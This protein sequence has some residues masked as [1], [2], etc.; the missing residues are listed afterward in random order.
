MFKTFQDEDWGYF[1]DIQYTLGNFLKNLC[2]DN[3]IYFKEYFAKFVPNYEILSL[4]PAGARTLMFDLYVRLEQFTNVNLSYYKKNRRLD[5]SDRP[6]VL[7]IMLLFL[8]IV[9]ETVNGPCPVNQRKI[10]RYRTDTYMG[11]VTREIDD[12]NQAFYAL[13]DKTLDYIMSLMEGEGNYEMPDDIP[14]HQNSLYVTEFFAKNT[15]AQS[16][17]NIMYK[18]LKKLAMWW[19]LKN[20]SSFKRK[21]LAKVKKNRE[22]KHKFGLDHFI[23]TE[24]DVEEDKL[25]QF[26]SDN[27][28]S[29]YDDE[30]GII[31]DEM[32]ETYRFTDYN[33]I[34]NF[35]K[36]DAEFSDHI[37]IKIA[38]KL[39]KLLDAISEA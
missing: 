9:S 36:H 13:K 4:K 12:V 19:K 26:S 37:I 31:T 6:E 16:L 28:Y 17:F 24:Q 5:V 27:M 7:I 1:Y 20:S 32:L 39:Y 23:L 30:D 34:L 35:Y 11:L 21:C 33:E 38:L 18:I 25:K 14:F 8:E 2:E 3:A 15:N 10:F 29:P 22:S